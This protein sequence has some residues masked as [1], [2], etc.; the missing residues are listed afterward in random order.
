MRRLPW[1]DETVLSSGWVGVTFFRPL[2]MPKFSIGVVAFGVSGAAQT[3]CYPSGHVFR[4]DSLKSGTHALTCHVAAQ[5]WYGGD[6]SREAPFAML[7]LHL[8]ESSKQ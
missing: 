5:N 3:L 7:P 6:Q 8:F 1:P 4:T 2:T